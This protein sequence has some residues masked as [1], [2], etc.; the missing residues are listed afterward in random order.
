MEF[1]TALKYAACGIAL[2]A[3]FQASHATML[4]WNIP[5]TALIGDGNTGSISGNLTYDTDNP[6]SLAGWNITVTA[7]VTATNYTYSDTLSG[8]S[9]LSAPVNYLFIVYDGTDIA[10]S[11]YVL[12]FAANPSYSLVSPDALIGPFD[13]TTHEYT[14]PDHLNYI[15]RTASVFLQCSGP[16]SS[17]AAVPEPA[18]AALIGLGLIGMG[19]RTRK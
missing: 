12:S 6:G 16:E 10:S 19:W 13:I 3:P 1:K 18:T 5:T 2:L 17:C 4:S 7:S 14:T 9:N 15:D 8:A 11:T